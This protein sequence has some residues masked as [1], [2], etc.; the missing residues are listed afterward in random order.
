MGGGGGGGGIGMTSRKIVHM[1]ESSSRR[2]AAKVTPLQDRKFP[3]TT[4]SPLGPIFISIPRVRKQKDY[5]K[6][7]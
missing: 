1:A 5:Y 4:V 3:Q 6:R 2:P 7:L